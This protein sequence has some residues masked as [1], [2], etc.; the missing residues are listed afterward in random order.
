MKKCDEQEAQKSVYLKMQTFDRQKI[1]EPKKIE[2]FKLTTHMSSRGSMMNVNEKI[3]KDSLKQYVMK[4]QG[5]PESINLSMNPNYDLKDS[6]ARDSNVLQNPP[7]TSGQI[8]LNP[9]EILKAA[10][11]FSQ[12]AGNSE[13]I[14]QHQIFDFSAI[15]L[16]NAQ[17]MGIEDPN[18]HLKQQ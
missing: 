18:A 17:P 13:F 3:I 12:L 14:R 15:S 2:K 8:E 9:A 11:P 16:K 1:I 5:N 10:R 7:N 6:A 4:E